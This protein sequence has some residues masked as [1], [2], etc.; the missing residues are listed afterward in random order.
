MAYDQVCEKLDQ[1]N[2]NFLWGHTAL[3]NWDTIHKPKRAG[4]LGLKKTSLMNQ[5]LLAKPSWRLL[6]NDQDLWAK[7]FQAK[8]LRHRDVLAAKYLHFHSSSNVWRG[9]L[10][11]AQILPNGIK[12]R[13]GMGDDLLFWIDN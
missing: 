12:C 11:G 2:K 10:Y 6:Q 13:V 9:V 5:V 1:L 4:G 3:V 8:Y 7:V